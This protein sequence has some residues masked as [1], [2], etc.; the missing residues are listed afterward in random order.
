MWV[1]NGF[2][3]IDFLHTW[4]SIK[5]QLLYG[6]HLIDNCE[7]LDKPVVNPG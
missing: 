6:S 3:T 2:N 1:L 7:V 5:K 4:N